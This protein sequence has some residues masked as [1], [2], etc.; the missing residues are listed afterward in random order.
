MRF[1]FEQHSKLLRAMHDAQLVSE[2]HRDAW[3]VQVLLSSI[4]FVHK[5]WHFRTCRKLTDAS[6]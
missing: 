6:A 2:G 3:H 5:I 4:F 1:Y